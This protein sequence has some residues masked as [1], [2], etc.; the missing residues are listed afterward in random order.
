MKNLPEVGRL[1]LLLVMI[2]GALSIA[3]KCY[4][5]ISKIGTIG[6][7]SGFSKNNCTMSQ[8]TGYCWTMAF[9]DP[10][11]LKAKGGKYAK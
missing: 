7:Q 11:L 5:G 10:D 2:E 1:F 9:T 8:S 6:D 3:S 4:E